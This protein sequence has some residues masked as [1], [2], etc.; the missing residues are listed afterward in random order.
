MM[1]SFESEYALQ[2]EINLIKM[3]IAIARVHVNKLNEIKTK[4]R[5][6]IRAEKIPVNTIPITELILIKRWIMIL[7]SPSLFCEK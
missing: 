6:N 1:Q 4:D 7:L 5:K 2:A 3:A